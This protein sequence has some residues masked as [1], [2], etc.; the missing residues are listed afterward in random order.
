M[1]AF[2]LEKYGGLS[3]RASAPLIGISSGVGVAYQ[4]LKMAE[5]AKADPDM[6]SRLAKVETQLE[7]ESSI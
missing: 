7:K 4:I 1:A 2:L 6:A 3:R 5:Q